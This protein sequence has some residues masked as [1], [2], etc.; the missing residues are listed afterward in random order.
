[1]RRSGPDTGSSGMPVQDEPDLHP[2]DDEPYDGD[3]V[4]DMVGGKP[5]IYEQNDDNERLM[6]KLRGRR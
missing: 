6:Q 1:M 5:F 4:V 3:T 2:V